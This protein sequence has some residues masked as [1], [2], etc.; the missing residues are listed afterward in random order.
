M[1]GNMTK[2]YFKAR[3]TSG[4]GHFKDIQVSKRTLSGKRQM[5]SGLPFLE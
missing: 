3:V 1:S 2:Y 4:L 5:T